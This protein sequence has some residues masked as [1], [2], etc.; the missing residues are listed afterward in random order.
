MPITATNPTKEQKYEAVK[1]F[2]ETSTSIRMVRI[3][4]IELLDNGN[5]YEQLFDGWD[6]ILK[7]YIN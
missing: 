4:A 3:L 6:S 2:I 7:D 1:I 5:D